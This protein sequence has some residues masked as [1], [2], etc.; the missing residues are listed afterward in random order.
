MQAADFW[1]NPAEAQALIKELGDLKI[2]AEG[3]SAWDRGGAI[4]SFVAGAGGD[5]AED[6]AAMLL[7]MYRKFSES[8]GWGMRVLHENQNARQGYRNASVE[9]EGKGVYGTLKN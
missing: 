6:F 4:L 3:G 1:S 7:T 5:D 8:R 2:E 9:I